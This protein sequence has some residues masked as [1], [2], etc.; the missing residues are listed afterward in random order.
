MEDRQGVGQ[1]LPGA[2]APAHRWYGTPDGLQVQVGTV[3]FQV[4]PESRRTRGKRTTRVRAKVGKNEPVNGTNRT[5]SAD[6]FDLRG[7]A[8]VVMTMEELEAGAKTS[9][10]TAT[11]PSFEVRYTQTVQAAGVSVGQWLQDLNRVR[12]CRRVYASFLRGGLWHT[13]KDRNRQQPAIR[14]PNHGGRQ[15]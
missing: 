7:T 13:A 10:T 1:H 11:H 14:V 9:L 2:G 8:R 15:R 4:R 6:S 12:W 3:G 5:G